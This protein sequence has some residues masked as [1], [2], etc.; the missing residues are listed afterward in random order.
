MDTGNM[1]GNDLLR[2]GTKYLTFETRE[3]IGSNPSDN[4]TM[5]DVINARFGRRDMMRGMLA[6]TAMSALF[7][8]AA[9]LA[10]REAEAATAKA[11]RKVSFSFQ[12]VAHGVDETHHVAAGYDAD[13]LIRWG[14]P[15]LP[16]APAFDPMKQTASAQ[17]MQ[18]G[19]NNDFVGYAPLPLGSK[20]PDR[21]L[22]CVN[23]EYTD[24]EVMFPGVGVEQQKDRFARM[25][26][27]LVDIEIAAHGGSVVEIRK[28]K[29]KWVYDPN[30][31]YNRR[32]TGET[33]CAIT[34]PAAGHPLMKTGNDPTGTR[35]RGMLN[36]CAGGMT[37]W[38]TW[39]SAE[40][41]VNGYFWGKVEDTNP[42]AKVLKRYGFPGE[43]YN[44]G[45]HHDRFDI[46]KEPNE[47]N[48]FGWIVEIDPYDPTSTPKKRTAL[49]RFKHEA[50]QIAVGKDG[51]VVAY[52][53]DDERFDYVYKFV[54][55]K[56][57]NAKN[58]AANMDILA[59]GTLYVARFKPDATVE[60]LPLVHGRGPLT[61]EKNFPDQA[62]VLINARLAADA[63]GATKMDRPE[64]IEVNA[65]TGKVYVMLTN[66][67]RRR[68]E[69]VDAA[70]PRADNNWGH[71]VEILP[72]NGDHASTKGRWRI[73]LRA[74]NP[75]DAAV[76]AQFHADTSANGWFSCP[77]NAAVDNRGRLWVT[78]DQGENWKTASGTTDGVWAVETEGDLRGLS[79]MFFRVPV[80]AEMCGPCFSPDDRTLFVAVQHPATDGVDQWD[81]FQ[82][83]R[84]SFEDPATRWPDFKPDMPPRPSVVAITKK[85]GGVIG[86]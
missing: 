70:N 69:Q 57:F 15:V 25:T 48:R 20:S 12:E 76:G 4:P 30:S 5:G 37:P 28:V 46:A 3:D 84:S 1:G 67:S 32:I 73:L 80:G 41:N 31:R 72:E 7:G 27:E 8:P 18:F 26:R 29:G 13:I 50:C 33:E 56:T 83:K 66:N 86:L 14:D 43:W 6:G 74:G 39:L 35:V 85:D 51:T 23:H 45:Q 22:L 77:D 34:G 81:K 2:K 61:A 71:I 58:R 82:G 65:K 53:G 42:N 60:W 21:A 49:G 16:G 19:Y 44:W 38:G 17:A 64:D 63:L 36:N 24:E 62:T 78:T 52:S 9:L 10:S 55:S 40:E 68:P 75:A 54:A 59:D 79:K 47:P 11:P